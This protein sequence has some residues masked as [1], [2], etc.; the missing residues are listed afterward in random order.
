MGKIKKTV[1]VC[2]IFNIPPRLNIRFG[3][4]AVTVG[5]PSRCGSGSTKMMQLLAVL[6]PRPFFSKFLHLFWT[7]QIFE[8]K[9]KRW[10]LTFFLEALCLQK[11]LLKMVSSFK[12]LISDI[13]E[14]FSPIS[15]C[16]T[17]CSPFSPI[18]E[19][20]TEGQSDIADHGYR[21]MCPPM[22]KRKVKR[23]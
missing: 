21:T 19:G 7:L 22:V 20:P 11:H 1:I 5:A 3:A 12:K 23:F 18:S 10:C 13:A 17:N 16:P 6:A 9:N 15:E 2:D 4:G 14:H 8:P